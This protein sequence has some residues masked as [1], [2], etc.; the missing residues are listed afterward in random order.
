MPP[1]APLG[2]AP[3]L[4]GQGV[5]VTSPPARPPARSGRQICRAGWSRQAAEIPVQ[6]SAHFVVVITLGNPQS[7]SDFPCK[8]LQVEIG[9]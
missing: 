2:T 9:V 4:P 3:P 8:S 6:H 7:D 5:E 1:P